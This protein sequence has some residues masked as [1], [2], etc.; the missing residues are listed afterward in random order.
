MSR[1]PTIFAMGIFGLI[2]IGGC[3]VGH[4]YG[5]GYYSETEVGEDVKRVTF[6]GGDH[7]M[8]GDLCLLRCAEVTLESGNAYFQVVDS[9]SG[10]S[11]DQIPSTYPFHR[12]YYLDDP[13]LR[14]T[15]FVTKTIRLLKTEAEDGFSY[16]AADVRSAMRGKYEIE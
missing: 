14:D 2:L 1:I 12:H 10:S 15:S 8:T 5:P 3:G 6:R 4:I 13:F 9:E 11:I 7:P 16:D